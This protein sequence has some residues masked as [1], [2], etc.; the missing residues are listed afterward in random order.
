MRSEV[1][2]HK[3][4]FL[5]CKTYWMTFSIATE[6]KTFRCTLRIWF[7]TRIYAQTNFNIPNLLRE[8]DEST[9]HNTTMTAGVIYKRG[10]WKYY[11]YVYIHFLFLL[12]PS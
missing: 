12:M 8:R 9:S 11:M 1:F 2:I 5:V 6:S 7:I 4:K 10:C 3:R